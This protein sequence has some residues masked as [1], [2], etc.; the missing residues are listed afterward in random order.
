MQ[1]RH[2]TLLAAA[3]AVTAQTLP[4]LADVL[5]A[6]SESLSSLTTWLESQELVYNLLANAEDVTLLAPS[7]NALQQLNNSPLANELLSNTEFLTA[8]LSYHVLNGTYYASNLTSAPLQ[9]I[10]TLLDLAGYGNITGGQKLI[11]QSSDGGVSFISGGGSKSTVQSANYNYTGG[12]IHIIDNI[13][14]IPAN[15]S[16]TALAANLTALV[17]AVQQAGLVETLDTTQDLTIFA[18]TNE[19]FASI[20]NLVSGLTVEQLTGI[21]GYH[22]IPGAVVYSTDVPNGASVKSLQGTELNFRVE[23]GTV[24]VNSAKVIA[25]DVLVANGVVHVIDGVLNPDNAAAQPDPAAESPAPAFSGASSVGGVPFTSGVTPPPAAT[26]APTSG[27]TA[28]P[29]D[30]TEPVTAGQGK[31]AAAVGAAA[32]FGGAAVLMNQL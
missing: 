5:A 3:K 11:A 2:L 10:P 26:A 19:A 24:W 23:D 28:P 21:L 32:L 27:T 13:L 22:V 6:Q 14:T 17:G 31:V 8:F 29:P 9:V 15:V 30:A 25:A 16:T 1:L 18:P 20:G 7:N 4:S 12:T